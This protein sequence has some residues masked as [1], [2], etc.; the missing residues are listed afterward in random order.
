MKYGDCCIDY[1]WSSAMI[2]QHLDKYVGFFER[3]FD[4]ARN[5][6]DCEKF[7]T[8]LPDGKTGYEFY[9][10]KSTCPGGTASE[11]AKKCT[12]NDRELPVLVSGNNFLYKNMFC[13]QCNLEFKFL[14]INYIITCKG[15][16][17]VIV[18]QVFSDSPTLVN[19]RQ[20]SLA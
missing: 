10:M 16:V 20:F 17:C 18:K 8:K 7:E 12:D 13:A 15:K 19:K 5:G 2:N 14:K 3:E 11:L 9:F 1:L 4:R 6:L